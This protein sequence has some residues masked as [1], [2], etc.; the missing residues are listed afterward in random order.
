M[1]GQLSPMFVEMLESHISSGS[2]T[3]HL[4][5]GTKYRFGSGREPRAEWRIYDPEAPRRLVRDPDLELGKSYVDGGWDAGEGGLRTLL[6][7]LMRNFPP[8]APNGWRRFSQMFYPALQRLNP[9]RTRGVG[10]ARSTDDEE[11]LFRGF[12]DEGL[13]YSSAYFQQPDMSL[14]EAQQAKCR[15]IL[16]K[17][18]L[19]AGDTVLDVG[20]GWGSLALYLAQ[21]AEGVQVVG[22]VRTPEELRVAEQRAEVLGLDTRVHFV[23][24]DLRRHQGEYD[25][26]VSVSMF[27][28]VGRRRIVPYFRRLDA[29]LKPS[30]VALLEATGTTGRPGVGNVWMQRYIVPEG[31]VPGLSELSAAIEGTDLMTTDIEILRLH[32][33]VTLE[34]WFRRFE[35]LREEA[36]GRLGERVC[37]MWEFYLAAS[38]FSFRWWDNVVFQIQLAKEH[39]AVPITRDYLYGGRLRLV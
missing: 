26:I 4:P 12:L 23:L 5:D 9:M 8:R 28:R 3:V 16:R 35:G 21:Q 15:H 24:E 7:V 2:L 29:L 30:G 10:V 27:E 1:G 18:R 34:H 25:R 22:L 36:E 20:S 37:R 6:D 32:S 13:F 33:A 38:E 17:L 31:Y 39:R 14:E 11:W 19:E